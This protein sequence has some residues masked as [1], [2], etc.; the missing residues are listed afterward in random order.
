L[1][2]NSSP[3]FWAA[4]AN[5]GS[6]H[7]RPE[8]WTRLEM[9][10]HHPT[11]KECTLSRIVVAFVVL[12]S[13]CL[14]A[15]AGENDPRHRPGAGPDWIRDYEHG[16][17]KA[18]EENKDLFLV[19]TGH[20]WCLNCELLDSEVFQQPEFVRVTAK[21][22]VFVELDL[23]FG[24]SEK[25]KQRERVDQDVQKRY[26]APGV[27]TVL[28]LDA[29]GVPFGIVTGY[30]AGRGVP[31]SLALI[32][33]ARA[34]RVVRDQKFAVAKYAAG[35]ERAEL[36]HA[37]L[38]AV[39]GPLGTLEERGDD[40]ILVFYPKVVAEI[41]KLEPA[42]SPVRTVYEARR[43]ERDARLA[44]DASVFKKLKEFDRKRDYKGAIRFLD[45]R[46]KES[47]TPPVRWRLQTARHTYLEWDNQ[48]AAALADVRKL[49]ASGDRSPDDRD[50]LLDREAYNLFNLGRINE[51]RSHY[52]Q[53][54]H[55]AKSPEKK[56]RLL[57]QKAIMLTNRT[58]ASDDEAIQAWRDCRQA[59]KPG[60]DRWL[61][62]TAISARLLKRE[63]RYNEALSL[64]EELLRSP[65]KDTFVLLDAAE[66]SL[67]LGNK[68][69][70]RSRIHE[71]EAALPKNSPLQADI[72]TVTRDRARI[73]KLLQ[74]LAEP[75]K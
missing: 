49:L 50:F 61:T 60:T 23:T 22:F 38:Q 25:E 40:P 46:L 10:S 13:A 74:Q 69:A 73:A 21:S 30:T 11:N 20:G 66:C 41:Q 16:L 26:L 19:L 4:G 3:Y 29:D 37:G 75:G 6:D 68:E 55:E 54:I 70:A 5:R 47:A 27:P 62:A 15:R 53:R 2:T 51:G 43:K 28:L 18:R 48:Y 34:A 14:P 7:A 44:I 31:K 72:A 42:N 1:S 58:G 65:P 24:D 35:H 56:L 45:V 9:A 8:W 39:S 67:K 71:A 64:F 57:A 12:L 32:E 59:A 52:D 63:G 17:R 36:L 33:E